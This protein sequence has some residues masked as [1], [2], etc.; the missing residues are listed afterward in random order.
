MA[1][2]HRRLAAAEV[3]GGQAVQGAVKVA[4]AHRQAVMGWCGGLP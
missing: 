4:D 3:G 1:D 2:V